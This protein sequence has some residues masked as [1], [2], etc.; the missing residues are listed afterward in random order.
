MNLKV[1]LMNGL[2]GEEIYINLHLCCLNSTGSGD[3]IN[4]NAKN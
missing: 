4:F 2:P 1:L 3:R